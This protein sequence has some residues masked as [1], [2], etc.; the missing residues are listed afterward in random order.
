MAGEED[1]NWSQN[2]IKNHEKDQDLGWEDGRGRRKKGWV[3]SLL[4][5]LSCRQPKFKTPTREM[6]GFV[7]GGME[8]PENRPPGNNNWGFP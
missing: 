7:S 3:E 1:S 2:S 5:E 4:T 6:R 8:D